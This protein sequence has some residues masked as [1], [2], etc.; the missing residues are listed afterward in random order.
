LEKEDKTGDVSYNPLNH[1]KMTILREEKIAGIANDIPE[2]E[3][4]TDPDADLLV[5]GW[6]SS[7]GAITAGIRRVRA[8]GLK[9]AQA[10]LRYINPFP[11]NL[12]E[13][14]R[15]YPKVLIPE[16]N[17]GQLW[18]LIRSEFLIDATA[19]SKVQGQPFKALEIESKIMEML[20]S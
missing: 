12:E 6:G 14:L 4:E 3:I 5:L 19:Y 18:R 20:E 16:L 2:I 15:R 13:I 8:R 11:R 10:H 17:R 9:V 1:E 7:Y